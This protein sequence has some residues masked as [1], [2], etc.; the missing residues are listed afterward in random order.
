MAYLI[1]ALM[2][3]TAHGTSA[4]T[5]APLATIDTFAAAGEDVAIGAAGR[6]HVLLQASV[7]N[8]QRQQS[9]LTQVQGPTEALSDSETVCPPEPVA[10]SAQTQ[11]SSRVQQKVTRKKVVLDLVE[12]ED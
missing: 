5:G 11:G 2:A 6:D 3:I 7:L 4:A 8:S 10:V 1:L 12:D 9:Q